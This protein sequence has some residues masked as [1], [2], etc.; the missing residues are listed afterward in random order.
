MICTPGV[1][2]PALTSWEMNARN[3]NPLPVLPLLLEE[4]PQLRNSKLTGRRKDTK[5]R[6]LFKPGTPKA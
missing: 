5:I 4:D 3:F 1:T 2:F 6:A